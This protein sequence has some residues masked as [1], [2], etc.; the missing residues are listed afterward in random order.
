VNRELINLEEFI[1]TLLEKFKEKPPRVRIPKAKPMVGKLRE[2]A[3]LVLSDIHTGKINNFV[4]LQTGKSIETYNEKIMWKEAGRLIESV[5]DINDLLRKSYNLET[6]HIF[7]LG[8][9]V[10]NDIIFSGQRFFIEAG[11]GA[12]VIEAVKLLYFLIKQFLKMFERIHIVVIGGNHGR[13]SGKSDTAHPWYNNL[14]WLVGQ[15]LQISFKDV[16]RVK[17][18]TPESWF[19]IKEINGW[20]YLLHHGAGIPCWMGFPYYGISRRSMARKAEMDIDIEIIGHFHRVF[21]IPISSKSLTLVNGCWIEKEHYS[22]QK[23]GYL[24]KPQQL[25]CGTSKKRPIT[26]RFVLDLRQRT[27]RKG[28][29]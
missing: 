19:F 6:L 24:T 12:Q 1:D 14:D 15:M 28:R 23:Y 4:D 17:I 8:D 18:E 26:W 29:E 11:A 5:R 22:W 10:D 21:E 13:L 20:K 2:D 16:D 27:P 25:Y 7:C 9:I 3:I